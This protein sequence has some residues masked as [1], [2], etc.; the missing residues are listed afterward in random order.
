MG[1]EV[2]VMEV[3]TTSGQIMYEVRKPLDVN[4]ELVVFSP[5]D[6]G[7][8]GGGSSSPQNLAKAIKEAIFEQAMRSLMVEVPLDLSQS[9]FQK[10]VSY[11]PNVIL[12]RIT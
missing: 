7:G 6:S 3:I 12:I 2:N 1:P 4:D 5:G 11:T 10:M 9:V 8:G